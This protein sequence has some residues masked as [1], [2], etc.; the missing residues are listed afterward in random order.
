[1]GT[2]VEV[3]KETET[4]QNNNIYMPNLLAKQIIGDIEI[5]NEDKKEDIISN[6]SINE[7]ERKNKNK[8][9]LIIKDN[10]DEENDININKTKKSVSIKNNK[11]F[12]DGIFSDINKR[13]YSNNTNLFI[14]QTAEA[15]K[16]EI[17]NQKKD[18]DYRKFKF[19]GITV[20]QNLKDYI[21]SDITKEEIQDNLN[22]DN[23][24]DINKTKK[25]ISI[26][27]NKTFF[28]SILSDVNKGQYFNN[29]N[30]FISQTAEAIKM[31]I[32]NQK[33]DIDYRKFKFN[34]ITVIQNLKDYIPNDITREEIKDM[35]Y[36]AFGEGLVDDNKYY[37]PGKTVT[38]KQANEIINL[39]E[40]Y[41]RDDM[42]VT[43]LE[44][45]TLLN[46][47]NL[48]ID[49][50]DLN[51]DIIK[52]KMF[53]GKNPSDLQLENTLKNLSGGLTNVK[54]L[55]IDFQ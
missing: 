24:I 23:N 39:I 33:K 36:N 51:K 53:K 31:E 50:V 19:N 4:N 2:E 1:M 8:E 14:S 40:S 3:R 16:M 9:E 29:T 17:T 38:K 37:I 26:K 22:S 52:E 43:N 15:I 46:G 55:S 35:V 25:T 41:I 5:T 6:S 21:P 54:I 28:N 11:T 32:T 45:N 47:V 49:L 34:G 30:L 27:N 7:N 44:N 18:I 48:V 12:F 10:L 42:I 20:I 13:Q